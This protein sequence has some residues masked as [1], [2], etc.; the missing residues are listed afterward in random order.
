MVNMRFLIF[1]ERVTMKILAQSRLFR[2]GA[3][4]PQDAKDPEGSFALWGSF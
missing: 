2:F 3:V 1:G 4:E